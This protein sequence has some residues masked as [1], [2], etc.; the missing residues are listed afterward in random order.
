MLLIQPFHDVLPLSLVVIAR[1]SLGTPAGAPEALGRVVIVLTH[2]GKGERRS[3]VRKSTA[4]V[5]RSVR[6]VVVVDVA[7]RS[8]MGHDA[9]E[10]TT[11]QYALI[12]AHL[13]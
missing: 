6:V 12:V 13:L 2:R 3:T 7:G 1:N 9:C 8:A 11:R 5:D 4:S 10:V